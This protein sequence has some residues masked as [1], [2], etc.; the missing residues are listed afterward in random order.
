VSAKESPAVIVLCCL[1]EVYC[2]WLVE[3]RLFGPVRLRARVIAAPPARLS[4][5][6]ALSSAGILRQGSVCAGQVA[7]CREQQLVVTYQ[8]R[9][10]PARRPCAATLVGP[11]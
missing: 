5:G 4:C 7:L 2:R 10:R 6:L 1:R 3:I 9:P 11:R 8:S